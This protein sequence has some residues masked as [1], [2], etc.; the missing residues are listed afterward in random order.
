MVCIE[1]WQSLVSQRFSTLTQ[2]LAKQAVDKAYDA[3][4]SEAKTFVDN[5]A[6]EQQKLDD[7]AAEY[8]KKQS[9]TPRARAAKAAEEAAK[10]FY[11]QMLHA[12]V[13]A[14]EYNK[15]ADRAAEE[16]RELEKE[17]R[18]LEREAQEV[19][20]LNVVFRFLECDLV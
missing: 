5:V 11:G 19:G 13:V 16:A 20:I 15:Q 7:G 2:D 17:A 12:G 1:I 10:P 4:E 8:R 9:E 3:A 18:E 6:I 14:R